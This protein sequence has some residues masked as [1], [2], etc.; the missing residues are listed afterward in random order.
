MAFRKLLQSLRSATLPQ[1][2]S[3]RWRESRIQKRARVQIEETLAQFRREEFLEFVRAYPLVFEQSC[4]SW[5]YAEDG[6]R[7]NYLPVL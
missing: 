6:K 3:P 2:S 1:S 4:Q 7:Y 5:C